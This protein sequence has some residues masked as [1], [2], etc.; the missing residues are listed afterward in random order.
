M[1]LQQILVLLLAKIFNSYFV[2]AVN[3]CGHVSPSPSEVNHVFIESVSERQKRETDKPTH[4]S[5]R[6]ALSYDSSV[7]ELPSDKQSLLKD[8]VIDRAIGY[9]E[10]ALQTRRLSKPIL[11]GRDCSGSQ[12]TFAPQPTEDVEPYCSISCNAETTCGDTVV[13]EEHL[14]GCRT[15]DINSNTY[16]ASPNQSPGVDGADFLLYVGA[17]S[18]DRCSSTIA[19]A[20]Y[21]QLEVEY[22]RPIAGFINICPHALSTHKSQLEL[23]VATIKHEILHALGFSLNLY[24]FYRDAAGEPLTNRTAAGNRPSITPANHYEFSDKVVNQTVRRDWKTVYNTTSRMVSVMVTPKVVAET[25]RHFNCSTL[26]GAEL[27]NQGSVGTVLTH[28]EKR[29]FENE[30]M[31][32]MYTQNPVVSRIT[33]ALMEDTGWY[34]ANYSLAEHLE[35][36]ENLGCDFATRSCYEWISSKQNLWEP[37]HPYCLDLRKEDELTTQCSNSRTGVTICNVMEYDSLAPEYQV[38]R[39][40]PKLGGIVKLA[41]YCPYLQEFDWNNE[42]EF[43]R[44]S[45]CQ[46]SANTPSDDSNFAAEYYGPDSKCFDQKSPFTMSR[47]SSTFTSSN[48][49][50]GCY[51]YT[52]SEDTGLTIHVASRSYRCYYEGQLLTVMVTTN[53]SYHKGELICPSCTEICQ[54]EITS[55][56]PE[57]PS[58]TMVNDMTAPD[59]PCHSTTLHFGVYWHALLGA[60]LMYFSLF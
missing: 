20:V 38:S 41:D 8:T 44:T 29:L 46:L 48:Y 56:P 30:M 60:L 47:C 11:L 14:K 15:Y 25:R 9:W 12:L 1:I 53:V 36:G 3:G 26:E 42:G 32:G 54:E 43:V 34:I 16:E 45:D 52:C 5:L 24:G 28:W 6:I 18:T 50:S 27:E 13:P 55:C 4:E 2:F 57:S 40:N 51:R 37:I 49:G 33:L 7:H 22:D 19:Y 59:I 21:C 35:W 39:E 23:A 31:T 17:Q 10:R 58:P